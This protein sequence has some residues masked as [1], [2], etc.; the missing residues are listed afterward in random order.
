MSSKVSTSENT[1]DLL[2][3]FK[4]YKKDENGRPI[5]TGNSGNTRALSNAVSDFVEAVANSEKT[6]IEVI[7]SEDLLFNYKE[8]DKKIK[9]MGEDIKAREDHKMKCKSCTIREYRCLRCEA[10]GPEVVNPEVA[11][12]EVFKECKDCTMRWTRMMEED[13]EGCGPGIATEERNIF[14]LG[15]DVVALFPSI[16]SER[17]GI[18]VRKRVYRSPLKMVGFEWKEGARYI[19]MSEHLTGPL[20]TLRRVI[21]VKRKPG[22]VKPGIT[23]TDVMSKKSKLDKQWYYPRDKITEEQERDIIS[24]CTEI[25][26]RTLFEKFTYNFGGKNYLQSKGGPIGARIT[27]AC[28]RLVMQ[29]WGEEL[30]TILLKADL[31]LTLFKTYVD[32]GRLAGTIL[33][34]G[35]RYCKIEKR[36]KHTPHD[37][38]MDRMLEDSGENRNARMARMCLPAM[39]DINPDLKFTTEVESD[40]PGG[41]LPTL[42]FMTKLNP[43]GTINHT[44]FQKS[45]KTPFVVMER[46]AMSIKQKHNILANEMIR[47]M[48]N[49]NKEGTDSEEKC[50]VVEEFTQELKSSGWPRRDA[51][52]MVVN[53]LLGWMRKHQRREDNHQSFYRSAASTL[54]M[55]TRKKLTEKADW[56]KGKSNGDALDTIPEE[57]GEARPHQLASKK[58]KRDEKDQQPKPKKNDIKGVI[59]CP[60]TPGGELARRIRAGEEELRGPTGYVVKVVEK[61]GTKIIDMVHKTNPW[62]GQDCERGGCMHCKTKVRTGKYTSQCCKKR[63]LVY[64]TWC[65]SCEEAAIKVIKEQGE[66]SKET[67]KETRRKIDNIQQYK[68]IGE[69]C[70]SVFERG[71]EHTNDLEQLNPKSHMLRHCIE[72]HQGEPLEKIEF[73]IKVVQYTRTSFERQILE[74]VKIQLN[75]NHHILN[76]KSEYNRCALPRLATKIGENDFKKW[77]ESQQEDKNKE[78]E[79]EKK[80]RD[81]RMQRNKKRQPIPSTQQLPAPK[82]RKVEDNKYYKVFQGQQEAEKRK[83]PEIPE[84][85]AKRFRLEKEQGPGEEEAR[86]HHGG[87][88]EDQPHHEAGDGEANVHH[89]RPAGESVHHGPWKEVEIYKFDYEHHMKQREEERRKEQLEREIRLV[90]AERMEKTWEL[91]RLCKLFIKDNSPHWEQLKELKELETARIERKAKAEKLKELFRMNHKEKEFVNTIHKKWNELPEKERKRLAEEE[92]KIRRLEIKEAKENIWKRWRKKEK[93]DKRMETEKGRKEMMEIK[94]RRIEEA[95]EK[96]KEEKELEKISMEREKERRRKYVEEKKIKENERIIKEK[97]KTEKLKKK[98]QLEQKWEMVRWLTRFIDENKGK[99]EELRELKEGIEKERIAKEKW[100]SMNILEKRRQIRLEVE[101]KRETS[102]TREAKI[103]KAKEKRRYWA[104]WRSDQT[105]DT[106]GG[107]A[108]VH[109]VGDD[110]SHPGDRDDSQT[111]HR[112]GEARVHHQGDDQEHPGDSLRTEPPYDHQQGEAQDR[113]RDDTPEDTGEGEVRV[114]LAGD[115]QDQLRDR[116]DPPVGHE[117]GEACAR[118]HGG[119]LNL[120]SVAGQQTT[121]CPP[122]PNQV[123]YVPPLISSIGTNSGVPHPKA[124]LGRNLGK[125]DKQLSDGTSLCNILPVTGRPLKFLLANSGILD[126]PPPPPDHSKVSDFP[127]PPP[128][129]KRMRGAE[130]IKFNFLK[131]MDKTYFSIINLKDIPELEEKPA[132]PPPSTLSKNVTVPT[133][134]PEPGPRSSRKRKNQEIDN[135]QDQKKLKNSSSAKNVTKPPSAKNFKNLIPKQKFGNIKLMFNNISA[136]SNSTQLISL[137]NASDPIGQP[138]TISSNLPANQRP[139]RENIS[140]N[141]E[142]G[143]GSEK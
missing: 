76:S 83:A 57:Q 117:G 3:A 75:R 62:R 14:Q 131:A 126:H 109:P 23:S 116:D 123:I 18:I 48:S 102:M 84:P 72:I 135:L 9:E 71:F 37:E 105:E 89:A 32:D 55:R 69:S 141:T 25:A 70:R 4:D 38:M 132:T 64:E 103:E 98:K 112:G 27:M 77:E 68:Y 5:A 15:L 20:G 8:H 29:D 74:S 92:D 143:A 111:D 26:V 11:S 106:R 115:D 80:I 45:M 94:L 104:D 30:T 67:E 56:Y 16:T 82:K 96:I 47:R 110:H 10:T 118:P 140:S 49:V 40:F 81:M 54:S 91:T 90:E 53:G 138:S 36:F 12:P 122:C 100:D 130:L 125:S 121:Q 101:E 22:G 88:N 114:H 137:Q 42:D 139:V 41:W 124:H 31:K 35:M 51:R 6:K 128:K 93:P 19:A 136:K 99:W 65:I 50:R 46:S 87:E 78:F 127:I 113:D 97:Q 13:C 66:E 21:P 44:Y 7:S 73:G 95:L 120:G 134:P 129:P 52:E 1:S 133:N 63:N 59:N 33:R 43:D 119:M 58:R 24:R 85:K 17:T 108:R 28:A 2:F 34:M 60:C 142:T 39:E 61:V 79:M 107:E 86:V